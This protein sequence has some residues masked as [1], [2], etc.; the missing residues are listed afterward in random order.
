MN[1]KGPTD[2]DPYVAG[3]EILADD[4]FSD[5]VGL[6]NTTRAWKIGGRV[7]HMQVIRADKVALRE[8]WELR[9]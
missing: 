7:L 3:N 4:V 8:E 2:C 5:G 6:M 1:R 9:P